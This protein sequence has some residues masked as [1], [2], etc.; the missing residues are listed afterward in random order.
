MNKKRVLITGASG[1]IGRALVARFLAEGWSVIAQVKSNP[2][3][4]ADLDLKVEIIEIDLA[5]P[6]NGRKLLERVGD[7]NLVIN[8]AADQAI[9]PPESVQPAELENIFQ[10]NLFAPLELMSAARNSGVELCI[11]ISSIEAQ[12][13]RPGHE[14]YGASKAALEALTKSL[15]MAFTPMRING[16]RLGLIGDSSIETRW[17][18]G[19]AAWRAA[20]PSKRY[21]APDEVASFVYAI[22]SKDF[23]YTTGAIFDFDGGKSASPGW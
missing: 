22:S 1:L 16:V 23:D 9:L 21:G 15:A 13:A 3:A 11:N 2:R 14:I 10:V 17:P 12:S 4:L 6:G 8:N 5:Q 7:V 19:V 20:V 18:E